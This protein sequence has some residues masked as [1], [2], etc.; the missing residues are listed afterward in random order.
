[1]TDNSSKL[2]A[3]STSSVLDPESAKICSDKCEFKLSTVEE[4]MAIPRGTTMGQACGIVAKCFPSSAKCTVL[5][6]CESG[7]LFAVTQWT[8][9]KHTTVD[10]S[11]CNIGEVLNLN[12]LRAQRF[13]Q[14]R[15]DGQKY[16]NTPLNYEFV[17]ASSTLC[18]K[19]QAKVATVKKF[20]DVGKGGVYG[21]TCVLA[22]AFVNVEGILRVVVGDVDNKRA[23]LN[24][25]CNAKSSELSSIERGDSIQIKKGV[26][27]VEGKQFF[28]FMCKF[29]LDEC[30]TI[31][32]EAKDV[33]ILKKKAV[34]GSLLTTPVK[35]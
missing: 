33:K 18:D 15:F 23:D 14:Q 3:L 7:E 2:Q 28:V 12:L 4:L 13:D 8:R 32:T 20:E 10:L 31:K 17:V 1:M 34:I 5:L 9:T 30:L 27:C 25:V 16:Y 19:A 22:A 26:F 11:K 21:I 24:V 35:S 6:S 29:F